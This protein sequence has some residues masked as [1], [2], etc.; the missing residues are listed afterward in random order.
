MGDHSAS[1]A[2]S[3]LKSSII[4][5][6]VLDTK[7]IEFHHEGD[8]SIDVAGLAEGS[9]IGYNLLVFKFEMQLPPRR[10]IKTDAKL[11]EDTNTVSKMCVTK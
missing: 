10:G 6:S 7:S 3:I 11:I 9:P 5:L 2:T 1:P 4:K 8:F